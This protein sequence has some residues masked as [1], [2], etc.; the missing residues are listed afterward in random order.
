MVMIL[1]ILKIAT[2]AKDEFLSLVLVGI[3]VIYFIHLMINIGMVVGIMPI[4]GIPL[5]F[6]SYGGSSLV[7]NMLLLGIA[8]NIYRTRKNYT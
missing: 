3:L 6:V 4:I 7:V 1:R 2:L 8:A 5:P